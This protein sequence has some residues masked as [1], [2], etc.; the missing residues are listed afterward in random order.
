MIF[1]LQKLTFSPGSLMSV[2]QTFYYSGVVDPVQIYFFINPRGNYELRVRG[3]LKYEDSS[4]VP[5][6]MSFGEKSCYIDVW[7]DEDGRYNW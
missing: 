5:F 2:D 7:F 6:S 4:I 1:G 3:P